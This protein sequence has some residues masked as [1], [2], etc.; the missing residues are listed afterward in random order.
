MGTTSIIL[1]SVVV[2]LIAVLVPVT[3][4]VIVRKKLTPQGK[5]KIN[6]NNEKNIEV[7]PGSSLLATLANEQIF[8]PSACGGGGN[9][10]MC[11]C[12]V[13]EG[14]GTILPTE[15][16]F[17]SR[18]EQ[19]DHWRLGCQVKVRED[20]KIAINPQIFGIK[21]WECEVVSNR[22]VATFIKEFVVKLPEGEHLKFESGGYIQIDVPKCDVNYKDIQVNEEYVKDWEKFHMFDLVMHNPEPQ[23][24]AYS[25]ASYPAEDNI[26]MLNVRIATPPFDRVNG[27][28][29]KVNP[30]VC[31]SYI[32]SLK[33]GDK[34]TI[35]GPYGEFHVKDTKREMIFIGGG[36]GMAPMRSHILDQFLTKHTDR[37]ASFWYGGRS[38]RELFYIDDFK[39]IEADNPNFS[40]NI[41]LSA[42]LPED[43]WT[44]YVGNIHEVLFENYLKNHPE[45]EEIE[46]YLCGPP[47]MTQAVLN[48]LDNLG[49][50]KEMIMFDDFGS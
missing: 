20:M 1:T 48:M 38:L 6:I 2:F 33:P 16:G 23:F 4:L 9:C 18:K 11:K 8:L 30:G 26:I 10:G 39:K 15:T 28:F 29:M 44:G 25:M 17:F 19:L 14:G 24:R 46:Y 7:E 5:V 37:K 42:P 21:K 45:P 32:Y 34:V 50:P 49:V 12:Q 22:N 47:M 27:G 36:A 3:I 43:N 13:L 40:F 41:A 31:S 35:S